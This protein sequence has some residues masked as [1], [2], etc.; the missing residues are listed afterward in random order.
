M[1]HT[2]GAGS[3]RGLNAPTLII[4]GEG[5]IYGRTTKRVIARDPHARLVIIARAGHVPW[6]QNRTT[7]ADLIVGFF[8]LQKAA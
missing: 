4:F 8:A 6:L 5:D 1:H 3:L 2:V 7:F